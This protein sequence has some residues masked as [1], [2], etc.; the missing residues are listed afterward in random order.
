MLE[1]ENLELSQESSNEPSYLNP[2]PSIDPPRIAHGVN[3][4]Q[5]PSLSGRIISA[6]QFNV[7]QGIQSE[8]LDTQQLI[9]QIE[10]MLFQV[11]LESWARGLAGQPI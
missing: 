9:Q 11:T 6:R 7:L 2:Q 5:P 1:D 10:F 3:L 8:L 4:S